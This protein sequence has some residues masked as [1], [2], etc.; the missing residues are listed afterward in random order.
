MN[1]PPTDPRISVVLPV[2]NCHRTIE[3]AVRSILAQ[4]VRDLELVVVDDGS[5]DGTAEMVKSLEDSRVR[6][7]QQAHQGVAA[8]ANRGVV[9]S[10]A[11]W[12]ARMDADDF[13]HPLRLQRQ[14]EHQRSTEA[15]VVGCRVAIVDSQGRAVPSLNRYQRWINEETMSHAQIVALRFVEFPLVNPTILARRD[16]FE[17]GFRKTDMPEDYELMLRAAEQ[18]MR[19][20]KVSA[21]LFDWTDHPGRL[22]RQDDCYS[23]DAFQRCRHQA[24]QRGPLRNATTVDVWGAGQTGRPWLRWL[25]DCGLS[26]RHIYDVDPRKIG[27]SWLR[28]TIQST[29]ELHPPNGTPLLVAV[30]AEG[31]RKVITPQLVARGYRL[32]VDAWFV[33]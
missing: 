15:D 14:L 32:G 20:E 8:A 26:I 24:L 29:S 10:R 28:S 18:G 16:Y 7:I 25:S 5:T 27:Q 17:L 6:L 19:F 2:H 21:M 1:E 23:P 33:A 9:E 22:T 11:S 13:S 12:I 31:A 30:G 4:T 3:R